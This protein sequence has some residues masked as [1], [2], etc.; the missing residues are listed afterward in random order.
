MSVRENMAIAAR[1]MRLRS[2][3]PEMYDQLYEALQ[4]CKG[5]SSYDGDEFGEMAEDIAELLARIDGEE[6]KH[7]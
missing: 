2:Y 4:L 1:Q 7:E 5:M 3:A 6:A